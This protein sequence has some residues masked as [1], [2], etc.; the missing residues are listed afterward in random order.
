MSPY[1]PIWNP[2]GG[3]PMSPEVPTMNAYRS[4]LLKAYNLS[5]SYYELWIQIR[6]LVLHPEFL[7]TVIQND[8]TPR[9]M[10]ETLL[11]GTIGIMY[12]HTLSHAQKPSHYDTDGPGTYAATIAIVGRKGRGLSCHETRALVAVL[13]QYAQA[14]DNWRR[15]TLTGMRPTTPQEKAVSRLADRIDGRYG[16]KPHELERF[17]PRFVR[18]PASRAKV[19]ELILMFRRRCNACGHTAGDEHTWHVSLPLMVGC[20]DNIKTKVVAHHPDPTKTTSLHN[21]TYMFALTI[22]AV[23]E[24]GLAPKLP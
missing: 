23:G 9:P 7:T 8:A 2:Q 17:K 1:I 20:G 14:H 19:A 10:M 12:H 4:S 15:Y 24:I 3:V 5:Q 18:T 11:T 6:N 16:V 22:A 13:E 21:T